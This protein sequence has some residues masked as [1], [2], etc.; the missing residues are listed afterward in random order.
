[1]RTIEHK[2]L[3]KNVSATGLEQC[4]RMLYVLDRQA[5][6]TALVL[7]NVLTAA[8]V[9]SP[10]N[11]TFR[12]RFKI[13]WDKTYAIGGC[14]PASNTGTPTS[15]F[16][17]AYIKFRRPINVEYNANIAGNIGD[18]STNSLYY[19]VLTDIASGAGTNCNLI[20][21]TRLR[22]TDQ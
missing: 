2:F 3:I 20:S 13:V 8:T 18:I 6:G 15:R 12:K 14:V 9:I 5:N 4:V 22:Y 10:R 17:K 16:G 1:M 7:T 21:Y 19:I 11:L